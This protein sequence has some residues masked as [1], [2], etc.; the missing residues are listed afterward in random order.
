M[1]KIFKY[2]VLKGNGM[3]ILDAC[4]YRIRAG[5]SRT[6]DRLAIRRRK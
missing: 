2:H 3:V 4:S 6:R 1:D 5:N